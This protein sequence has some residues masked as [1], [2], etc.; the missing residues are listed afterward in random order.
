M[1]IEKLPEI[2]K[3]I[4]EEVET[5]KDSKCIIKKREEVDPIRSQWTQKGWNYCLEEVLEL[6]K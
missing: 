1:Q 2:L 6:L 5:L 4:R 3:L